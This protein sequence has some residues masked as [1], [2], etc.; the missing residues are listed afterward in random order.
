M[1]NRLPKSC[2]TRKLAP[3]STQAMLRATVS[4]ENRACAL[5]LETSNRGV[6]AIFMESLYLGVLISRRILARRRILRPGS[7]TI[8][9]TLLLLDLHRPH[10]LSIILLSVALA[11]WLHIISDALSMYV[12]VF[13]ALSS[14]SLRI[15]RCTHE[16]NFSRL[17]GGGKHRE[18]Y[19]RAASI[20]NQSPLPLSVSQCPSD[21][22]PG[23]LIY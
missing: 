22:I 6:R 12:C 17:I 23:D 11:S 3:P 1:C 2:Y 13:Q 9:L 14:H 18:T 4:C 16:M 20:F 15:L 5:S 21:P 7:M 10:P 8:Q 19:L